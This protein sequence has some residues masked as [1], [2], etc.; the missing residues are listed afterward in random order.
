[1]PREIHDTFNF[2]PRMVG[3]PVALIDIF[4]TVLDF[5]NIGS[6]VHAEMDGESL[7]PLM[8]SES[9][10]RGPVF[11]GGSRFRVALIDDRWKFYLFD[12]N[13]HEDRMLNFRRP[14]AEAVYDFREQ[15]FNLAEDPRET[16]N[17][18]DAEAQ[19][20][21]SYRSMVQEFLSRYGR[22]DAGTAIRMNPEI[23]RQLKALGYVR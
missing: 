6:A 1:M 23:R 22:E 11:S 13:P 9:A 20:T 4:P 2:A 7:K 3:I 21:G 18:L 10:E 19:L 15:L 12:R 5:L 14:G 17:A 8:I 16:M